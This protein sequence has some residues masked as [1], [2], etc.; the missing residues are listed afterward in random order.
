MV[1]L[2][3][4]SRGLPLRLLGIERPPIL[5]LNFNPIITDTLVDLHD[6]IVPQFLP[7]FCGET[8]GRYGVVLKLLSKD[9][10]NDAKLACSAPTERYVGEVP[11]NRH[12]LGVVDI[13]QP[14]LPA[15]REPDAQL[16]DMRERF[17]TAIHRNHL[18]SVGL[19]RSH[20]RIYRNPVKPAS[21]A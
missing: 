5:F 17:V 13:E 4:L 21:R 3:D 14:N 2:W 6:V 11:R 20:R 7:Q 18:L 1:S 16:G 10:P 15:W 19:A 12:N 8:D 9:N